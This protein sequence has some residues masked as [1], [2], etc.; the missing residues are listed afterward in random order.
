VCIERVNRAAKQTPN[1]HHSSPSRYP[2][3]PRVQF[4]AIEIARNREGHNEAFRQKFKQ[5]Q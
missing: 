2:T 3:V 5:Q 1:D 4:F